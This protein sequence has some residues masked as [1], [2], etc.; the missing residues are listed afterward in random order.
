MAGTEEKFV[1]FEFVPVKYLTG[2]KGQTK[3]GIKMTLSLHF[4]PWFLGLGPSQGQR[5]IYFL[6]IKYI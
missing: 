3:G 1:P 2:T 5:D 4:V 6:I